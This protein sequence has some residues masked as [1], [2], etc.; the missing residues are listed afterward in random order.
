MGAYINDVTNLVIVKCSTN[1]SSEEY[2]EDYILLFGESGGQNSI[3]GRGTI[4]RNVG[5][6]S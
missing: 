6:V 1:R 5:E 2:S 4:F 3:R